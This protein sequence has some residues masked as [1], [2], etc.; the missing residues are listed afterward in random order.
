MES[1]MRRDC[2]RPIRSARAP[3]RKAPTIIPK[4]TIR[5]EGGEEQ[6]FISG[7]VYFLFCFLTKLYKLLLFD[8][9]TEG[10]SY[11][12][13]VKKTL[14]KSRHISSFLSTEVTFG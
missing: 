12:T 10:L 5:P 6:E 11:R 2:R 8:G 4:Y 7:F 1:E 3:Q 9:S 13:V 14:P